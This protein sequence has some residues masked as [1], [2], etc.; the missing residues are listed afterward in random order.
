[1]GI[2]LRTYLPEHSLFQ[3]GRRV[4]ACLA[5]GMIAEAS[6]LVGHLPLWERSGGSEIATGWKTG[7]YEYCAA[8]LTPE[9]RIEFRDR[10]GSLEVYHNSEGHAVFSWPDEEADLIAISE[11]SFQ[12]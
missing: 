8:T 4:K 7:K 9:C 5:D 6:A 3:A 1:M 11:I 12:S 10:H 2:G